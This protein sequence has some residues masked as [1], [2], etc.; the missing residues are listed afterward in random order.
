MLPLAA[1]AILIITPSSGHLISPVQLTETKPQLGRAGTQI[2][3][4]GLSI[5]TALLAR[6]KLATGPAGPGGRPGKMDDTPFQVTS[7]LS[8]RNAAPTVQFKL[9]GPGP[10]PKSC[11]VEIYAAAPALTNATSG[12]TLSSTNHPVTKQPPVIY[13][14]AVVTEGDGTFTV[15]FGSFAPKAKNSRGQLSGKPVSLAGGDAETSGANP[16]ASK[17]IAL[18]YTRYFA[19]VIEASGASSTNS[20]I[21]YGEAL[22]PSD[23][24]NIQAKN[25]GSGQPWVASMTS[26]S[27]AFA[28]RWWTQAPGVATAV[29]QVSSKPFPDDTRTWRNAAYVSGTGSLPTGASSGINE[30]GLVL[31]NYLAGGS[32]AKGTYYLRAI[33]LR[34]NGDLAAQPSD[35]V[36]LKLVEPPTVPLA[37][38]VFEINSNADMPT[39]GEFAEKP[40]W[41]SSAYLYGMS[42][43]RYRWSTSAN[44][45]AAKILVRRIDDWSNDVAYEGSVYHTGTFELKM[46]EGLVWP[47]VYEVKIIPAPVNEVP[48]ATEAKVFITMLNT[49]VIGS[50]PPPKFP[51]HGYFD[52]NVSV[53]HYEP[54]KVQIL[55]H[56][57]LAREPLNNTPYDKAIYPFFQSLTGHANPHQGDK[58]YL[59]PKQSNGG[60]WTDVF[61]D[62]INFIAGVVSWAEGAITSVNSFIDTVKD[63]AAQGISNVTGIPP[64][65]IRLGMDIALEAMGVPSNP[66]EFPGLSAVGSD[67]LAGQILDASGVGDLARDQLAS[68]IQS[69]VVS[70]ADAGKAQNDPS[71]P[72]LI[73]DPDY[74]DKNPV[75]T[76]RLKCHQLGEIDNTFG[77]SGPVNIRVETWFND[78]GAGEDH[79]V[80][81][82]A[83]VV[84]PK[85][86]EGQELNVPVV[87]RYSKMHETE[88]GRWNK[89]FNLGK[90]KVRFT[91]DSQIITGRRCD[92]AWP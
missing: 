85:M 59:P 46:G 25:P 17:I 54:P 55:Y 53:G 47:R 50:L 57:I 74:A 81:Y 90:D 21:E 75:M 83:S 35:S 87:L 13:K 68:A 82:E 71:A 15:N 91:V 37:D 63:A 28:M 48:V 7:S 10:F 11:T 79:V 1:L 51:P 49:A 8:W 56:Y 30:F 34:S 31:T 9:Q 33:P 69:G 86:R 60:S 78:A 19:R 24:S 4:G 70:M 36:I 89:A 6:P 26:T 27:P 92:I 39:T 5:R 42:T 65:L 58:I 76:L 41:G 29:F 84:L 67:Y 72:M 40:V 18:G 23:Q 2:R 62:A 73:P 45:T 43:F 52:F 64:G 44:T 14:A 38:T 3:L 32:H 66:L 61:G 20:V 80:L 22:P 16:I 77:G 88:R 12:L